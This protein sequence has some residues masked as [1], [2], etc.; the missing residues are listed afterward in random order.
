MGQRLEGG[1]EAL[2]RL[3][4]C[5]QRVEGLGAERLANLA[6]IEETL[7]LYQGERGRP[8]GRRMLTEMDPTQQR[9]F[10]LFG[11]QAYA[12]KR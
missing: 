10:D 4:Q 12:P 5:L 9:L 1:P 3:C 6:G 2:E 8:R 7:L 11:L